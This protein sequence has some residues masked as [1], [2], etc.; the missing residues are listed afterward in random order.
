M[1]CTGVHH[2]KRINAWAFSSFLASTSINMSS[3]QNVQLVTM[4]MELHVH[5]AL[6][7]HPP[8]SGCLERTV[9]PVILDTL[10]LHRR[11]RLHAQVR[12]CSLAPCSLIWMSEVNC[13]PCDPG[14]TT[15]GQMAETSCSGEVL[16][17]TPPAYC[18][19][20]PC[21]SILVSGANSSPS[22]PGHTTSGEMAETSCSGEV[23]LP[24]PLLPAHCF[25]CSLLLH[26]GD[27]SKL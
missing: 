26:Q 18:S 5:H 22:S 3:S 27:W 24:A 16:L 17:P 4:V 9:A 25:P 13:S 23:L 2:I 15:S 12:L 11:H 8:R 19:L 6:Q 20:A 7:I 14:Y 1:A 21:S 10:H